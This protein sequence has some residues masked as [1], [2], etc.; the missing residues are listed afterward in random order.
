MDEEDS[1]EHLL[2]LE[3]QEAIES[4][5]IAEQ[6]YLLEIERQRSQEL[7]VDTDL[8]EEDVSDRS[9]PVNILSSLSTCQVW[10]KLKCK[11]TTMDNCVSKYCIC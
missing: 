9:Q 10:S 1:L 2:D 3:Q 7:L 5:N 8:D 6:N 4:A 11:I